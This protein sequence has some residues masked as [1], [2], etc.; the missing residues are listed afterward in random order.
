M[1]M[2]LVA[3]AQVKPTSEARTALALMQAAAPICVD[4]VIVAEATTDNA[5]NADATVVEAY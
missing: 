3:E 2:Q 5:M 1:Q 4:I